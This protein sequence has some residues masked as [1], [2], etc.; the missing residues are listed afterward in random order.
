MASFHLHTDHLRSDLRGRSVRGAAVTLTTRA[1]NATIN[2]ASLAILARLLVHE[3]F[4]L[5]FTVTAITGLI[6]SMA[7]FG[8]GTA[9]LQRRALT[10]PQVSTL[11]WVNVVLSLGVMAVTMA[12]APVIVWTYGGDG[13][14]APVAIVYG[15]LAL[16]AGFEVQHRALLL[17]QMEF[18]RLAIIDVVALGA[19]VCT[20]VAA[21]WWGAGYWALVIQAATAAACRTAGVWAA[22]G[23]RP[24][25]PAPLAEVRPLLSYGAHLTAGHMVVDAARNADKVLLGRFAGAAATGLYGNAFRLLLMPA[26]HIDRP[27]TTVAVGALSRLQDEPRRFCAYYR[28]AML[29]L[30][31]AAVPFG[32]FVFVAA[33]PVVLAALGPRWAGAV[34]VVRLLAPAAL[35][36]TLGSST[37]W[38]YAAL[39]RPDRQAR[40]AAF[41]SV[42]RLVAVAVGVAWGVSGV[43]I[44][45]S[46]STVGL[47]YWGITYCFR[48]S[49]LALRDL[50]SALWRPTLAALAAG[51]C[52]S[53]AG[54][55][56]VIGGAPVMAALT[57]FTLFG[58]VYGTAWVGLPGGREALREMTAL[59]RDLRPTRAAAPGVQSA[60]AASIGSAS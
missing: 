16:V 41:A 39:G 26:N 20:A 2:F 35:V 44:A 7:N 24:G 55:A 46:V 38:V 31:S 48:T 18:L 22:C 37:A 25:R 60:A 49:P 27:L 3:D 28:K 11:F 14:L 5:V 57:S 10:E 34:P 53:A 42:I 32:V 36:E 9:T 29:L 59:A 12:L 47:R 23:W 58:L 40:W 33:E 19:S 43:A 15:V 13:R 52:L 6:A 50:G 8:L 56:G 21:A 30:A 54:A 45:T 51:A 17:R 4:G 1:L